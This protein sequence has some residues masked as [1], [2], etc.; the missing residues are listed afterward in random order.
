MK[1]AVKFPTNSLEDQFYKKLTKL[2]R[3]LQD[4]IL[5]SVGNLGINPY[6][7]GQKTFKRLNPPV[8]LLAYTAQYRLR[9]GD[10]RVLYDVD[11]KKRTVWVFVLRRRNEQT[12]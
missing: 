10:Y 7:N 9:L 11:E 6:P 12:Y 1:Y 5:D 3:A 4:T 2:P 8:K